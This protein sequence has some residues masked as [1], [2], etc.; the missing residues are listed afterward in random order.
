MPASYGIYPVL[1]IA[2]LEAYSQSPK[3]FGERPTKGLMR[4]DFSKFPEVEIDAIVSERTRIVRNRRI[5]EFRIHYRGYPD[6]HDAWKTR[7]QLKNAPEILAKWEETKVP[8]KTQLVIA[9]LAGVR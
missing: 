3:E 7:I 2:H 1:N 5:K 8:R 4:A 9:H 6:S